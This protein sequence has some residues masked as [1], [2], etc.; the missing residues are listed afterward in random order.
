[1]TLRTQSRKKIPCYPTIWKKITIYIWYGSFWIFPILPPVWN[2]DEAV[3]FGH[4][5]IHFSNT[6]STLYYVIEQSLTAFDAFFF[7]SH[8]FG[9]LLQWFYPVEVPQFIYR[10]L[11]LG[12]EAVL[13]FFFNYCKLFCSECPNK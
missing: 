3:R 1:M 5:P 11:F 12:T 10:I 4:Y 8:L 2:W 13:G 7:A 6:P 9:R